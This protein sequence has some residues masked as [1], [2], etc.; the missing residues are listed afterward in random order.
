VWR[1]DNGHEFSEGDTIGMTGK[2]TYSRIP[3]KH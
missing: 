1:D 2:V 3:P